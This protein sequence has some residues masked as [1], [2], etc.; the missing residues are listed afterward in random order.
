M[1]PHPE[2]HTPKARRKQWYF[3]LLSLQNALQV[4]NDQIPP[5]LITYQLVGILNQRHQN[6]PTKL[7]LE[8]IARP[9]DLVK[10]P[11]LALRTSS[12]Q[13]REHPP[14]SI[15]LSA[16]QLRRCTSSLLKTRATWKRNGASPSPQAG[17]CLFILEKG[18]DRSLTPLLLARPGRSSRTFLNLD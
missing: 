6:S 13:T 11:F 10:S 12:L 1:K 8:I 7:Q 15:M 3:H 5:C 14:L 4:S 2:S 18:V 16:S 17:G 9:P